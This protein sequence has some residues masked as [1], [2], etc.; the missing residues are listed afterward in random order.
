MP[1]SKQCSLVLVSEFAVNAE[2][3]G[4]FFLYLLIISVAT[5]KPSICTDGGKLGFKKRIL[6]ITLYSA[7]Q[8]MISWVQFKYHS[9]SSITKVQFSPNR[10]MI[11][12][13]QDYSRSYPY[14]GG[15]C[16]TRNR[17]GHRRYSHYSFLK[18]LLASN[19][20]FSTLK[21]RRGPT[22]VRPYKHNFYEPHQVQKSEHV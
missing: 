15:S 20:A 4:L 10:H 14:V 22:I 18:A 9:L 16:M 21:G 11:S 17:R 3:T 13:P 2:I 12:I 19:M 5:A 8:E 7:R 6:Q 1:T